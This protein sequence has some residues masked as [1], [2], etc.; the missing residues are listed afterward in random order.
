MGVRLLDQYS[1]LHFAV[2]VA[3]YFWGVGFWLANALHAA[4]EVL[5]NTA[6]GMWAINTGFPVWPGGKPRADAAVN[7]AGD[8][9]AF[10]AGWLA[11]QWLDGALGDPYA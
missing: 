2:G 11:A 9:L 8:C 10:A 1:L 3:A 4:F 7:M 6:P 5:E